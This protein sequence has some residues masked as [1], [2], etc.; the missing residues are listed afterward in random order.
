MTFKCRDQLYFAN[1]SLCVFD[2]RAAGFLL[3]GKFMAPRSD[4]TLDKLAENLQQQRLGTITRSKHSSQM[5]FMGSDT[6]ERYTRVKASALRGATRTG[7]VL[8]LPVSEHGVA[9][10]P[11][12]LVAPLKAA[13]EDDTVVRCCAV[14]DFQ[15]LHGNNFVHTCMCVSFTNVFASES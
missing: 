13:I 3:D 4:D 14:K 15:E 11:A 6:H 8:R 7:G 1:I 9:H 5:I 2:E 12:S 10:T